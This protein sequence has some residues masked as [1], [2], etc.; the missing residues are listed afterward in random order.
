MKRKNL[1]FLLV[2][3]I[4]VMGML[5]QCGATPTPVVVEKTV[6]V[7]QTVEVPKEV[8]VQ[9]T[10]EVPVEKQVVVTAT[11]V[12]VVEPSKEIVFQDNQSGSNFQ[13]WFQTI[14]LPAAEKATGIKINYVVG[15][16]AEIFEKM[17]AWEP[18]KGDFAVLFPKS[19]AALIKS[20]I[21]VEILSPDK[22]P[23]MAKVDPKL[24]TSSEGVP[25]EDKAV[26]YWFSTYA[27]VWNSD[28]VKDP[29]ETWAEFYDR[30]AEFKGQIGFIRP[31]AKSSA[32]WR[33][34]FA[35][36]NA[37][38]DF[39]KPFDPNDPEFQAAWEKLKDF[40]TYA[41]LPLAAEPSPNLFEN[42]NAGD[43][44]ISVYA[45][46]YTLWSAREGTMPPTMKAGFLKEGIDAGGQAYFAVPANISDADKLAAY[47]V[48]NFL[49][50]DEMQVRLV[51]TMWQ[52]NSTLVNDQVPPIVWEQIP[53]PDVAWSVKIPAERVNADAIQY[54]KDHGLELV[55]PE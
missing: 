26:A 6:V 32:G 3:A 48:I 2:A 50:S 27:L 11:P 39:S 25:I 29:P 37:F 35:F 33:Q 19:A 49:L 13:Q 15:K 5:T 46:D 45:M 52:Y 8:V 31:D 24:Q 53:P 17:K 36:L 40:Y 18:G 51:S 41:T 30:R 28:L 10:V 9:Q 43:T 34:P 38:Y 54:I 44:A 14:A 55:P 23:N 12:P 47:Q 4:V 7:N 1:L 22:I 42:F 16:D 21:P 20:E